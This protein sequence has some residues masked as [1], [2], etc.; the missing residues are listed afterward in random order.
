MGFELWASRTGRTAVAVAAATSLLVGACT[1][2]DGEAGA[3]ASATT[4]VV[5]AAVDAAALEVHGSVEQVA[6]MDAPAGAELAVYDAEGTEVQTGTVDE[7]G[8][9]LFRGVGAGDGYTVGPA[10]GDERSAAVDVM[11]PDEIPDQA[12]YDDQVLEP[13]FGY[14][15]TRDGTTLSANVTLPGPIEDGPYPTLVEYSG[16]DPSNPNAPQPGTLIANALGYASVGVNIRGTGCSGGAFDFF[17]QLQLLDGYDVI[18]TVAAQDW[19]KHN[20]VG[21]IGLSYP[22]ISQL[23]VASTQPPSLA[24]ITPLSVID[25][26]Y[27]G[28]LYPGGILNTGFGASWIE[29]VGGRAVPGGQGWDAERID[30]GDQQC[31]DN[32]RLRGQNPDFLDVIDEA[33]FFINDE[34]YLHYEADHFEHLAPRLFA[35]R[36]DVPVFLAGAWQDEQTGGR[37]PVLFPELT[38]SPDADLTLYNGTHADGFS[39]WVL[40]RMV[41]FLSFYVDQ[42]VPTVPEELY[43]L[44]PVAMAEIFGQPVEI[45][46]I[47]F[48]EY[49]D[50]DEALAAFQAEPPVRVLFESGAGDAAAPGAPVPTFEASFSA[51]PPPSTEATEWFLGPDGL[52]SNEPPAAGEGGPASADAFAYDPD[53]G[54]STMEVDGNI[55]DGTSTYDWAPLAEGREAVY[56]S[57][58]FSEDT[59]M[60]GHASADLWI[61]STAPDTDLEVVITE[62]RPD[63]QERYVTAGW[64]RASHRALDEA[65]STDLR[66]VHTHDEADAEDLPAGEWSLARVEIFPFGHVFRE[67]TQ[68]RVSVGSPGGNRPTWSFVNL[69]ADGEV[70]NRV[71]HATGLASKLVLPVVPDLDVAG[72][73]APCPSLRG[74]PCRAFV[75]Y[76]NTPAPG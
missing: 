43:A 67:G 14:I 18:E 57:E 73:L 15:T 48:G 44:A 70:T 31:A 22:G 58:P 55:F 63:G 69:E 38:S 47:R 74:Q 23:F 59:V 6:V 46:E 9:L 75:P 60:L 61:Q 20:K 2:D 8:G 11:D 28:T 39:P 56:L 17:E 34:G 40:P 64:L 36:I 41:E 71:A 25:D 53:D 30:E 68:L 50:Y 27:G 4:A 21:M 26:A 33:E 10:D 32:T 7:L 19:V 72:D 16:Y 51:W 42:E 12:L 65:A 49:E 35:D 5:P 1:S 3:G 76:E 54:E 52:L 29:Q 66:P 24:A 62:V 13:G 45:L 37:F